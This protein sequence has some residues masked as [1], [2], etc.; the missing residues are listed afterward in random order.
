M[1]AVFFLIYLK[2]PKIEKIRL[3]E[4]NLIQNKNLY[5]LAVL[6]DICKFHFSK[7]FHPPWL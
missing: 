5:S 1:K 7:T 6:P 4:K 2:R 3:I